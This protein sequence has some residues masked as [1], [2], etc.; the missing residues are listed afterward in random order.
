MKLPCSLTMW[1]LLASAQAHADQLGTDNYQAEKRQLEEFL[2]KICSIYGSSSYPRGIPGK[3]GETGPKGVPGD[4]GSRGP[5]G[6]LGPAGSPGSPGPAGS[7]GPP[8]PAGPPGNNGLRGQP[9]N[10]GPAGPPGNPGTPAATNRISCTNV[11]S[12]GDTTS[13]PTGHIA[14]SCACGSAC[15]SWDIPN[16]STCHCQCRGIDWTSAR[17]CKLA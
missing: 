15:G 2:P 6:K 12:R 1:L 9:G 3:D 4:P 7:A 13:C 17:C 14:V 5:P 10:T 16:D 11:S 8:G